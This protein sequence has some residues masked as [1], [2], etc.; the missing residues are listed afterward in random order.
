MINM[1]LSV[2][3]VNYQTFELTKN[4]KIAIKESKDP[5]LPKN[6]DDKVDDQLLNLVGLK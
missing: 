5:I 1:D 2:V 6:I 3:I 4:T